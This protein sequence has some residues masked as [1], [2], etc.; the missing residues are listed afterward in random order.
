[1][2]RWPRLLRESQANKQ[3]FDRLRQRQSGPTATG[4]I[5]PRRRSQGFRTPLRTTAASPPPL[6]PEQG[7]WSSATK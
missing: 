4:S 2:R 7:P 1:M 5:P 3:A 6:P